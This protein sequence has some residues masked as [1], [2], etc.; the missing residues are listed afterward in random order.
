M[1][2]KLIAQYILEYSLFL[3]CDDHKYVHTRV[4]LFA[5]PC[6]VA[7]QAPLSMGLSQQEYWSGLSFPTPGDLPDPG[8]KP[9][10]L[11]PPEWQADSW[12]LAPHGR[13]LKLI[14]CWPKTSCVCSKWFDP[15][16]GKIPWRRK[17]QPTPVFLLG[18]FHAQRS[19]VGYSP[20]GL[21]E[22]TR[23]TD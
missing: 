6:T 9:T 22:S 15:W 7:R 21:K 18:K 20:W 19:L 5:T 12:P 16:V 2:Y 17:W 1:V 14:L 11:A 10:S 23:L 4:W 8:I 13:I 3:T